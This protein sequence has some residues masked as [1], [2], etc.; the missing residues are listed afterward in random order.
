MFMLVVLGA[1]GAL[2]QS[3][4]MNIRTSVPLDPV[5]PEDIDAIT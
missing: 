4:E 5:V 3:T 1:V 2:D